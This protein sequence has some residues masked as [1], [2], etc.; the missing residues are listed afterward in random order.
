[1][2]IQKSASVQYLAV[3]SLLMDMPL[4]TQMTLIHLHDFDIS[5]NSVERTKSTHPIVNLVNEPKPSRAIA[6]ARKKNRSANSITIP[7]KLLV[8]AAPRSMPFPAY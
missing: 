4:E 1:M 8:A 2:Q 3:E 7:P 6:P 5:L